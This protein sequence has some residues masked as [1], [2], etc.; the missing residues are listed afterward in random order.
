M[1]QSAA[2]GPA[3]F[4]TGL[5]GLAVRFGCKPRLFAVATTNSRLNLRIN[6][7]AAREHSA[8]NVDRIDPPAIVI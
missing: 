4:P 2:S 6:F 3:A 8:A 7:S 5:R 1:R